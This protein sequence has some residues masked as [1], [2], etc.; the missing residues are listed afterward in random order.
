MPCFCT[1]PAVTGTYPMV[2]YETNLLPSNCTN[3]GKNMSFW[4]SYEGLLRQLLSSKVFCWHAYSGVASFQIQSSKSQI[5]WISPHDRT[6]STNGRKGKAWSKTK[7]CPNHTA[8]EYQNA[9]QV[10]AIWTYL[11]LKLFY[12]IYESLQDTN[13]SVKYFE[14]YFNTLL[15]N[16][17][18]FSER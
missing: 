3:S 13:K 6:F 10:V 5:M 16:T 4:R 17:I 12:N 14:I 2:I 15:E 7:L 1:H 11:G 8:Q 9:V 18:H